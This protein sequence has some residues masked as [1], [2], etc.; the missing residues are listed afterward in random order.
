MP[1]YLCFLV[2]MYKFQSRVLSYIENASLNIS[3]CALYILQILL[4]ALM[5]T[6]RPAYVERDEKAE[7]YIKKFR[8]DLKASDCMEC[9]ITRAMRSSHCSYCKRCIAKWQ[10]HS[11]WFNKCIDARNLFVYWLYNLI[12]LAINVTSISSCFY[13]NSIRTKKMP[14]PFLYVLFLF[15][16]FFTLGMAVFEYFVL[17]ARNLTTLERD[18]WYRAIFMW[19]NERH[20]YFNPFDRGILNN[21]KQAIRSTCVCRNASKD[22]SQQQYGKQ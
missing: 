5:L 15:I 9:N 16:Q 1:F 3:F 6:L 11:H 12:C 7:A 22:G 2:L 20:E 21:I 17:I 8:E 19:K 10:V 18:F 14:R 4:F 13:Y